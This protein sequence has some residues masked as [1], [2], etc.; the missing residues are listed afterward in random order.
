MTQGQTEH[1]AGIPV[2]STS[3]LLLATL[4]GAAA[5]TLH[6]LGSYALVGIGCVAGWRGIRASLAAGTVLLTVAALWATVVAWREWRRT[7]GDQPWDVALGEPR[8]W[9]AFL[10]L[11]GVLLGGLSA[12]TILLEGLGT[13][14]LPVCD[15]TNR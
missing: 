7:S 12:V 11:S 8:G 13:L 15:W 4:G 5:W 3:R 9:V 14:V 2:P 10:M 1:P 6:F